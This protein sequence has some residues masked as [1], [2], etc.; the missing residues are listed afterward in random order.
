MFEHTVSSH[1]LEAFAPR[2]AYELS[3]VHLGGTDG[4]GS[5]RK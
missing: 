5:D 4:N 1:Y 2:I 3:T